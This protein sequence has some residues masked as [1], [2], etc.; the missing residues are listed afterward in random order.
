MILSSYPTI[1]LHG[2]D[3]EYAVYVVKQFIED[4]HKLKKPTVVIIHGIGE[5]ILKKV[6]HEYLK[7]EPKVKNFKVDIINT[8]CTIVELN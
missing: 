7:K 6:I 2:Y 1:D 4:N 8:G 3:R 5:G